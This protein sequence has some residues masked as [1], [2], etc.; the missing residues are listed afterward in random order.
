MLLYLS[1]NFYYR[2]CKRKQKGKTQLAVIRKLDDVEVT[3]YVKELESTESPITIYINASAAGYHITS[4][5][6]RM[7]ALEDA[8]TLFFA[9]FVQLRVENR[10]FTGN[11]N[12]YI[13]SRSYN[14]TTKDKRTR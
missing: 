4:E 9:F 5:N 11:N 12:R 10:C 1:S 14:H 2:I 13:C 6:R 8:G 7:K 3:D